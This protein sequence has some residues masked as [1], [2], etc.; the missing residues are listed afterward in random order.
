MAANIC[1]ALL[2]YVV[3]RERKGKGPSSVAVLFFVVAGRRGW[4]GRRPTVI[5]SVVRGSGLKQSRR[6][7]GRNT[8]R[9]Y[10]HTI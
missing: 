6:R 8:S 9:T 5:R 1:F 3:H 10:T 7:D 4:R 2:S